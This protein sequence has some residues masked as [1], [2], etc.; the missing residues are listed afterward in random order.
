MLASDESLAS[1]TRARQFSA[2]LR[3]VP[4]AAS[5]TL[6]NSVVIA[7]ILPGHL[8]QALL[9]GWTITM[10]MLCLWMLQQWRTWKSVTQPSRVSA[11]I[12]KIVTLEAGV[13]GALW[14]A[15]PAML[16]ARVSHVDFGLIT[17]T[18][19]VMLLVGTVTLSSL[20]SAAYAFMTT[21]SLGAISGFLAGEGAV[22]IL[23]P[24]Q[25]V[26]CCAAAAASV[27]AIGRTLQARVSAEVRADHQNQLIG[28]LL[29][30]FEEHG[31]DVLWEID[32]AGRLCRVTD[33]FAQALGKRIEQVEG[34]S[35][36]AL[37]GEMQ[38]D[39]SDSDRESSQKLH[40]HLNDGQPFRDVLLP[41]R[42]GRNDR[43]WSITAKPVVDDR[44]ISLGW[45]GVARD[46]TQARVADK[47]LAWLANFDP[48]TSLTNR[49]RFRFLMDEALRHCQ[50]NGPRGAVLCLDLDNFKGVNDTLGHPVGDALLVEVGKRLRAAVGKH[51]VV[52][53]LGGD[54]FSVLVRSCSE[55]GEIRQLAQK[56][57]DSFVEPCKALGSMVPVRTSIGIA[58]YPQDGMTVDQLMQNAD[59]AL[60]DAKANATGSMRFFVQSMGD[61]VKRKLVLERDLRHALENNQ[62]SLHFQPKVDLE[63]WE[64]TGFEALLRWNH[65][66]HGNIPPTEFIAVAEEGGLILQMGAWAMDRACQVAATWPPHL[67]V[68]VNISPLQ[69]MTEQLPATVARALQMSGLAPR[70]LELEITESVFINETR[71]TVDRLHALRKLGVQIALDD[72]GTGYSSLAYLRRFPFD[73][74]KIDRAFVRELLTSRDARA[75]VRNI[76]ALAKALRMNTVAEGVEEPAQVGVLEAEGCDL[77]QGY[78]VARPMPEEQ[79]MPFVMDFQG[80]RRP[81][82]PR[83]FQLG[84]TQIM[85]LSAQMDL[86]NHATAGMH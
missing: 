80:R 2:V 70:R 55:E 27:S 41:L 81:V 37:L 62:L 72:F 3:G 40:D 50:R 57:L 77:V 76:L 46:V 26:L 64:V 17:A 5:T 78:F 12:L 42:V 33:Q 74:L 79:V 23:G 58:R 48:L 85:E 71:G 59:L 65:P 63:N 38:Q 67:H 16:L 69:V 18:F 73:T 10:V 14:S 54:E 43:W 52:A 15:L 39:L 83:G 56:V 20:P 28:L 24:V 25:W 31:S 6:L 61:Q 29:R 11:R 68:A 60:Y 44:G 7:G 8:P 35:F 21:L 47:K 9:L 22:Q 1:H 66:V 13:T 32:A 84:N 51:D 53:R 36:L 82:L 86:Q 45:R 75:I 34:R 4:L 30:D 49:A 19:T